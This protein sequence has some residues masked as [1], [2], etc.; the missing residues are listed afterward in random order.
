MSQTCGI[1][2]VGI[3]SAVVTTRGLKWD[4]G[5]FYT[6]IV[7]HYTGGQ[8]ADMGVDEETSF[9]GLISTSNHLL[10][11]EPVVYLRTTR[12]VLWCVEIRH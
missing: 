10:P 9:R 12:P 3:E 6:M 5:G 1:L 7:D 4:I 11:S 8:V 2:P